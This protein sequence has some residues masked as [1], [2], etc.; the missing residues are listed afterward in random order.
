MMSQTFSQ[1]LGIQEET[2][3]HGLYLPRT[4]ALGRGATQ[5]IGSGRL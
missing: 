2:G 3:R 5:T 1:M 4:Y